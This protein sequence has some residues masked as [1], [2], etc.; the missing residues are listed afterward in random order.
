MKTKIVT[1]Y[2]M[3][4][5]GYPFQG[6]YPIR[7]IRY[8]GSLIGHCQGS[9]L[10]VICYTHEKS[11]KELTDIKNEYN[12]DNLEIKVL[13]L[14]QIKHHNRISEIR[15]KNFYTE[16]V[17]FGLDGR[18]PEIM[19]GKFDVLERE[20]DGFDRVYW[21]D[22]GLQHPGIFPWRYCGKYNKVE[23]HIDL[24]AA[25]WS[26]LEV[27]NCKSL[28]NEKIYNKLD[29]ICDNKIMFLTS[30]GP[31]IGYP[32]LSYGILK[33]PFESPYPVAGMVGGDTK[34]LKKYINL[35]WD[36]AE[37]VLD[38]EF[39]CVEEAIMKPTYDML[40]ENE[41]VDFN[42]TSFSSGQ[43]DQFH[44]ERWDKQQNTPKPFYMV[45]H[46][47]LNYNL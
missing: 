14:N 19:W 10:P 1:A 38:S 5:E 46:D 28:L 17:N 44:F 37:K 34:I 21:V 24:T 40:D 25:W 32:F 35:F 26:D 42:F 16:T 18:G 12:L 33:H 4:S 22:S 2:W 8:L 31:Q 36:L 39:L 27:F 43:H 23:D 7:K 45:W 3:D 15:D 29:L 47:I 11:L 13:E 20:L 41:K 6:G 9:N 30:S